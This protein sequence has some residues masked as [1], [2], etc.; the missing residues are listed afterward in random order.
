MNIFLISDKKFEDKLPIIKFNLHK[1]KKGAILPTF[2]LG[3]TS[4][5]INKD[6]EVLSKDLKLLERAD[7]ILLCNF[8]DKNTINN[9][10]TKL[11]MYACVAFYLN[12]QV[13]ILYDLPKRKNLSEIKTLEPIC[14]EGNLKNLK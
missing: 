14:L 9:I 6:K 10:S 8:K 11:L 2:Q 1:L 13:F 12:K 7:A 3:K 5:Y 4:N